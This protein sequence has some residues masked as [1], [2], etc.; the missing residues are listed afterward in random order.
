MTLERL[1]CE[2]VNTMDKSMKMDMLRKFAEK[3][4]M[5]SE[6]SGKMMGDRCDCK[7][8]ACKGCTGETETLEEDTM[9]NGVEE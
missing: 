3:A 2:E 8:D 1:P 7:C 6:P 5:D 9:E 4:T